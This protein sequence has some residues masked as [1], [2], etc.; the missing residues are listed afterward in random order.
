MALTQKDVYDNS[1]L[2]VFISFLSVFSCKLWRRLAVRKHIAPHFFSRP[3]SPPN[4]TTAVVHI[5]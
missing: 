5:Y 3:T 1:L 4:I 2:A